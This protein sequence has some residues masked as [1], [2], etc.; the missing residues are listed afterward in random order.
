MQRCYQGH[1]YDGSV[2]AQCPYCP[3]MSI[4]VGDVYR[5][6]NPPPPPAT[7]CLD[8]PDY[9]LDNAESVALATFLGG[10]LPALFCWR[11]TIVSSETP[12]RHGRCSVL[13]L[14]SRFPC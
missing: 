3:G 10:R 12:R 14:A 5:P 13:E 7:P 4:P 1:F 8:P 2:Q 11:T 9:K 6:P